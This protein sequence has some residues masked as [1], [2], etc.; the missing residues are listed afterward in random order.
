MRLAIMI[1][2]Y[3]AG[4][5]LAMLCF[6]G[7]LRRT[8]DPKK[9]RPALVWIPMGIVLILYLFPLAGGLVPSGPV[10]FF[11]QKWGNLFLGYLL[12]FFA[13]LLIIRILF[14]FQHL[15]WLI[16]HHEIWRP[17]RGLSAALLLSLLVLTVCVNIYGYRHARDVRVTSY[18]I[19]KEELGQTELAKIIL[20][21]D[22]H[23]GVNSSTRIYED[24]VERVNEQDADLILIAGDIVTSAYEAMKDPDAYAAVL[25]KMQA[26]KGK[27]VIYGNHDVEEPLLGGFSTI[28]ADQAVRH[29][30]TAGFLK[31]CGW[32]LLTDEV[33]SL[34]EF[35]GLVLAGR[36][37]ESRPGDGVA[38]RAPLA[39]LLKDVPPQSPILLLQHEPSDL[40]E[41]DRYG[42]D[43]SVS[44]HTHDGQIFPGNIASRIRGPQ[45]YGLKN[46][47]DSQ[48]LVTSGVGF[49]GP[50]IRVGT[51]SEIAVINLK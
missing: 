35:N 30:E 48:A 32:T 33:I 14:L 24:M 47:G 29:P 22:L 36:R 31:K 42:V 51:I 43:L 27:Y 39:V 50:P 4:A 16:R 38:Q 13:P 45:S 25:E 49:Y 37:D 18:E 41:L 44:G 7:P 3:L 20:I 34:P 40:T 28:G 26:K 6:Y 5:V 21:G 9:K 23:M 2:I 8:V 19:A 12:Y 1:S 46:W 15:S 17:A 10:C 11:F